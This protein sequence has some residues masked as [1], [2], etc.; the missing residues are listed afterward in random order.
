MCACVSKGSN[1]RQIAFSLVLHYYSIFL[2]GSFRNGRE[3]ENGAQFTMSSELLSSIK[4]KTCGT[5]ESI[6]VIRWTVHS[7][8]SEEA[9]CV[10]GVG[11]NEETGDLVLP[12]AER[13]FTGP[14]VAPPF[15]WPSSPDLEADKFI[16]TAAA[17]AAAADCWDCD[18]SW[19]WFWCSSCSSLRRSLRSFLKRFW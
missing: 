1:R 5:V 2:L 13:V 19:W 17:A 10:G 14:F 4:T 6:V 11:G 15:D 16:E 3:C 7:A 12:R 18:D 9:V 8:S